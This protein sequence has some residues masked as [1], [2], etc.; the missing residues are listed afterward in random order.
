MV[1]SEGWFVFPAYAIC[2]RRFE[3]VGPYEMA[4]RIGDKLRIEE[5][6]VAWYKGE[7]LTT[8]RRGI[9]P[10]SCVQVRSSLRA[11]KPRVCQTEAD[12]DEVHTVMHEWHAL[13]IK[14]YMERRMDE[15]EKLKGRLDSLIKIRRQLQA[16]SG[17]LDAGRREKLKADVA[18]DIERGR[19]EMNLDVVVRY[20]NGDY[21][22]LENTSFIKLYWMHQLY[23]SR[24]EDANTLGGKDR[25]KRL[26]DALAPQLTGQADEGAP[27]AEKTS[28]K[29]FTTVL[30][31]VK[32]A[33]AEAEGG[34]VTLPDTAPGE[35]DRLSQAFS[36]ISHPSLCYLLLDLKVFMAP[37]GEPSSVFFSLWSEDEK[38]FLTEEFQVALTAHGMPADINKVQNMKTLFSELNERYFHMSTYLYCRVV[39]TGKMRG[40]GESDSASGQSS[41]AAA[42]S[43]AAGSTISSGAVRR[44]YACGLMK[45]TMDKLGG[46]S[47]ASVVES[48]HTIELFEPSTE[49]S[50][51]IMPE[52]L[53]K[54]QGVSK[55]EAAKGIIVGLTVV[56][57]DIGEYARENLEML[58]KLTVT[59]RLD[60]PVHTLPSYERNDLFLTIHSCDISPDST[61]KRAPQNL[62]LTMTIR[63]ETGAIIKNCMFIGNGEAPSSEY[64]SLIFSHVNNPKWEERVRID[65]HQTTYPNAHL[66]MEVRHISSRDATL[67]GK[68]TCTSHMMLMRENGTV[69]ADG[70]HVL[71]TYKVPRN[72]EAIQDATYYL[73]GIESGVKLLARK[74]DEIRITSKLISTKETQSDSLR[75]LL[76]WIRVRD[77]DDLI[78][79]ID[80]ATFMDT[81]EIFNYTKLIVSALLAIISN[82]SMRVSRKAYECLVIVLANLVDQR[83]GDNKPILS[84]FVEK[85][86]SFSNLHKRLLQCIYQSLTNKM[87]MK[88]RSKVVLN[89]LRTLQYLIQMVIK[90]RMTQPVSQVR[91][92]TVPPKPVVAEASDPPS[93]PPKPE[94]TRPGSAVSAVGEDLD[95]SADSNQE[96]STASSADSV[97]EGDGDLECSDAMSDLEFKF[98]LLQVF[99]AFNALM[100]STSPELIGAQN[101]ALRNFTSWFS[102]LESVFKR[103][104][105]S[106]IACKF[107]D[108]VRYDASKKQRNLEKLNVIYTL[109]HGDL[110]QDTPSRLILMPTIFKQLQRHL[111][112]NNE[113][114]KRMCASILSTML[115]RIETMIQDKEGG[116]WDVLGILPAV[117][118]ATL[119]AT[120]PDVAADLAVCLLSILYLVRRNDLALFL[121][122]TMRSPQHRPWFFQSFM[123]VLW[124]ILGGKIMPFPR[125]W[126]TLYISLFATIKKVLTV[127]AVVYPKVLARISQQTDAMLE[128]LFS[129]LFNFV[130]HN[131][132]R[133][134]DLTQARRTAILELYGDMR[135]V[136]VNQLSLMWENEEVRDSMWI[137]SMRYIIP[138]LLRILLLPEPDLRDASISLYFRMMK[139]E[140][141]EVGSFRRIETHTIDA[142]DK[143]ANMVNVAKFE[144]FGSCFSSLLRRHVQKDTLI[145]Q[146]GLTYLEDMGDLLAL[147]LEFRT[148]PRR[149]E[150]EDDL[151]TATIRLMSYLQNTERQ[152]SYT[153]FI[154]ILGQ[155]HVQCSNYVEAGNAALLH[156]KTLEWSEEVLPPC[157]GAPESALEGGVLTL[158]TVEANPPPFPG[159]AGGAG[160]ES[161]QGSSGTSLPVQ[162]STQ[163]K[164]ALYYRAIRYY[165]KG[166]LYERALPI[167]HELRGRYEDYLFDYE[168]VGQIL[169]LEASLYR[170][171]ANSQRCFP[172]YFRV[173][174]YGRGFPKHLQNLEYIHCGHLLERLDDFR[175]RLLKRFPQAELLTYTTNPTHDVQNS[176]RQYLQ[177][178]NVKPV[179]DSDIPV[180]GIQEDYGL[181]HDDSTGTEDVSSMPVPPGHIQKARNYNDVRI[182]LYARP[183]MKG[184]SGNEHK[185][186][187]LE[188]VFFSTA[189]RFPSIRRSSQVIDVKVREVTPLQNATE[190]IRKKNDE[191]LEQVN[192]FRSGISPQPDVKPFTMLLGGIVDAAVAGG[193]D[194]YSK[195][196]FVADYLDEN[197][198]DKEAV[199]RLKGTIRDHVELLDTALNLHGQLCSDEM[200]ALQVHLMTKME[201]LRETTINL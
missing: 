60:Y 160:P 141:A 42:L 199:E 24:P 133:L 201:I 103:K 194:N 52:L 46:G 192:L 132:L 197:P 163:R 47:G 155:V 73:K 20:P 8:G 70:L 38:E 101:M 87:Q 99:A 126:A 148:I 88:E 143:I 80:K 9:F 72:Q 164:M 81:R 35:E 49:N 48:T 112:C 146:S 189:D 43:Q 44:P 36:C 174:Y 97:E 137:P 90:S 59:G 28:K 86:F 157:A 102:D 5:R 68:V 170:N 62:E 175:N 55:V 128:M 165:E 159:P 106:A 111:M 64:K 32:Q 185:D 127:I 84:E 39:R 161:E 91:K 166:Q 142:L 19:R 105:L 138:P 56:K 184:D 117:T 107:V 3:A 95:G 61:I 83:F 10:R 82:K 167:L 124:C 116:I 26:L 200:Q 149:V 180:Y 182:F 115:D 113:E 176:H 4:L 139:K 37:V 108:A 154:E 92:P 130:N 110:Y 100:K 53:L 144:E 181:A 33:L 45:V 94:R 79:V 134:S 195:A 198:Q 18:R 150:Y 66:Y 29:T 188:R 186:L 114:E 152:E 158:A 178:M 145:Y 6:T 27:R 71:Q 162:T 129:L 151:T 17:S 51:G 85:Y 168:R 15:F 177:I 98:M 125:N 153:K 22:T 190:V 179:P 12:M 118:K 136:L 104:E 2:L 54:K 183:V 65:L 30:D 156:G 21:A 50:F 63:T 76:N 120:S 191:V 14:L 121:M 34:G 122:K 13:L 57:S 171:M 196:F 93:I 1:S 74:G 40:A 96:G 31:N 67:T 123:E 131:D 75:N 89:S 77:D 169:E 78:K 109:V 25:R 147:M 187:W 135:I 11:L 23:T 140:F 69:I 41:I 16:L 119:A 7:C 172:E 193:I 58:S 173:G